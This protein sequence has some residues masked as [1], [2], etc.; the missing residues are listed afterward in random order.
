[1]TLMQRRKCQKKEQQQEEGEF[2]EVSKDELK[3][4]KLF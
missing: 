3:E 1:M 2:S 4:L